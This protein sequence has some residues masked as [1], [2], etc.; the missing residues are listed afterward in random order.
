M[1]VKVPVRGHLQTGYVIAIKTTSDYPKVKP[2]ASITSEDELISEDLFEL[3]LWMSRYYV[4]PL[5]RI[6]KSILPASVRHQIPQ[7]QQYYVTRAQ[8]KEQLR[9]ICIELRATRPLHARILEELLMVDKG[10]WLTELLE[11]IQISRSP[12]E[13]LVKQKMLF[14]ERTQIDRSPL[15]GEKYFKTEPK[16]LN[17][18]QKEALDKILSGLNRR[19][20][21]THLLYG[22]TGSG[23]TEVYLQA[24]EHASK[25]GM[26][27]VML[28]PE[29]ALTTQTIERFRARFDD[30]I[31]ILHHRLSRGERFDEWHRIRAGKVKIVIGARSALFSPMPHLGLIIVD[32]EH[33]GAYKQNE[34]A[35][36]YHARDVA[37]MRGKFSK[38]IVVLGTAT[39][40]MESYHNAQTG[41]YILSKLTSRA[42][43]ASLPKVTLVD[44]KKEF[45]KSQGFTSFSELLIEGIKKRL[46]DGEQV[47]LFLNRRGY[48]TSLTCR[49]C[50]HIFKCSHCDLPLTFHR[51]EQRLSCHLC[52]FAL[53]PLPRNCSSCRS[54]EMLKFK[55]VGTEQI[56][57]ALHALFPEARLL[58]IDGDTTRH[59]GSHDQ[60]F[61]AFKTGKADILIGTQMVTKGLH[62]PLVTLVAILN[63]DSSLQIPDFRASEHVFQ[64]ITQVAGRSG[65]GN[66]PGEVII[67]THIPENQTIQVAAEQNYEKFFQNELMTRKV[68]HFPPFNRLIKLTFS[69]K[70][71]VLTEEVG[72]Q[73][74]NR[75][76]EGIWEG[77]IIHPL[78]PSGYAKIKDLFRFHCLLRTIP[79]YRLTDF[80]DKILLQHPLPSSVRLHIDVDPL[81]TFF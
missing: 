15:S 27:T 46:V 80:L 32:E 28:V 72:N 18:E 59:K 53:S 75:L 4:T 30:N 63:T 42:T 14:L 38:A 73:F 77:V 57:R 81:S 62:F 34:E 26:G 55:G 37:V 61:R 6:L 39:P 1:Q 68:F 24:I 70:D 20:Y 48:H 17:G 41:K 43:K 52:D 78:I 67:Q 13:T 44:M 49:H 66:F 21:E 40:S 7:K 9:Q 5:S 74:R 29:I 56:E 45:E 25:M 69:G 33:D 71:P 23:K 65:R 3:I 79:I 2:I 22:V 19:E 60:L 47:I 12:V 54:S 16:L 51:G 10:I 8:S 64:L 58:R 35:P 36:S 50:G 11:K 31:A 76:I